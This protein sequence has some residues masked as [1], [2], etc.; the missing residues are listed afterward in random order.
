MILKEGRKPKNEFEEFP[1]GMDPV[2]RESLSILDDLIRFGTPA[3]TAKV[4]GDPN[5]S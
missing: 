5:A 3:R 1:Y 2:K 4:D